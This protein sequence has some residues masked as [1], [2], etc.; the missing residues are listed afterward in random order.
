[1]AA[2]KI[3]RCPHCKT[4]D[5][6]YSGIQRGYGIVPDMILWTCKCCGTTLSRQVQG[7]S[8]YLSKKV[9]S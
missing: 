4:R 9:A 5:F 3:S 7:V 6:F 8:L 2:I 1:M